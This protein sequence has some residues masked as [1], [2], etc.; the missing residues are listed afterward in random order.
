MGMSSTDGLATAGIAVT[1]KDG[2]RLSALAG[3]IALALVLLGWAAP[4]AHAA[5]DPN[6]VTFT[7][8]GCRLAAGDTLPNTLGKFVCPDADYT[9][10]NLGKLWNELDL[11]PHRITAANGNGQQTYAVVI[12]ADNLKGGAPGYDVISVPE[13]NT[14]LSTNGGAGCSVV[15]AN[16][17]TQSPGVG[18]ADATIYRTLTITQ[19]AGST[20]VFD[21]YERLALGSHLYS[22][23]SLH[24]NLLNQALGSAGIGSKDVSIPVKEI[25]PQGLSKTMSASQGS[26]TVWNVTKDSSPNT[27]NFDTCS[28]GTEALAQGVTITVS[29]TKITTAADKVTI[30]TN[31][32]VTN[33]AHRTITATVN[34]KVYAGAGQTPPP[35]DEYTFPATDVAADSSVV[36]TH[37]YTVNATNAT[38]YN[39]VAT[40]TYT[41]KDTGIT[42]PGTTTA[43]A[44]ADVQTLSDPN[45]SAS[46]TDTEQITGDGLTFSV[47]SLGGDNLP[48]DSFDPAYTLGDHTTG[49][50]TWKSGTVTSSGHVTFN[51]TVYVD[52]ARTTSGELSDTATLTDAVGTDPAPTATGSTIIDAGSC[53]QGRKFLDVNH[54]GVDDEDPGLAGVTIYVDV[55]GN[56]TLDP[57][58]EQF[59]AVTGSDGTYS[60]STAGLAAGTYTLREVVADGYTCSFPTPCSYSVEVGGGA[61][62]TGRDFGNFRPIGLDLNKKVRIGTSGDYVEGPLAAL[63][64]ETV[65]YQVSVTNTGHAPLT[66][67]WG[68]ELSSS[69]VDAKCDSGTIAGPDTGADATPDSFDPGDVWTFTCTHVVTASDASPI[70]NTVKVTGTDEFGNTGTDQDSTSVGILKPAVAIDKT[71]PAT[72][73]AGDLVAYTLNITNPGNVSYADP[74]VVVGDPLC[75]APPALVSKNGDGTPATFDPG[76]RWTYTC[77]VQTAV[78][79]T[80]VDNVATVTATDRTGASATAHAPFTT[81][82]AQPQVAVLPATVSKVTPG[83]AKLRGPTGC[84]TSAAT[85]A[86]VTGKRITKVTFYVDGKKFKTVTRPDS[87]GR[88]SVTLKPKTLPY[89]SHKVRATIQFAAD[90]GTKAKTLSLTFN[91]CRPAIVNPKFTG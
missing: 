72:A 81:V 9:T 36:L 35:A 7:L 3:L 31:I 4:R 61:A 62:I 40:A 83:S 65:G 24:S 90:S 30:V 84:P 79:Q 27:L 16:Q 58:E 17:Q 25:Q 82:M 56:G 50:V 23:S 88:W 1:F 44:S 38:Q 41:D 76:D 28:G 64:G 39:D 22:G 57:E 15:A 74:L 8:E 43:T 52:Q 60:I 51:K 48:S 47:D 55:N 54:N 10:G 49:P 6:H 85:K 14:S 2:R 77:S 18:G 87:M 11:V 37:T 68:D 12:A 13:L 69:F 78:G 42:V 32:T 19:A 66:L 91:R 21:Y 63:V 26:S 45:S 75:Q 73:T 59:S 67:T 86:T 34:D 46:I 80:Q 70:V 5:S 33:P 71:G 89:G 20:C 53:I 29:W